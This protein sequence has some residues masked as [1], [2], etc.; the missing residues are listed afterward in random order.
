MISKELRDM[1]KPEP[2]TLFIIMYKQYNDWYATRPFDTEKDA[3]AHIAFQLLRP[4]KDYIQLITIVPVPVPT[5][6]EFKLP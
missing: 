1:M 3:R 5:E 6:T 2:T 4:E